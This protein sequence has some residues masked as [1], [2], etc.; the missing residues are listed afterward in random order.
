VIGVGALIVVDPFERFKH[1]GNDI[2]FLLLPADAYLLNPG[3]APAGNDIVGGN[4]VKNK[5][6]GV[7]AAPVA[8]TQFVGIA[9]LLYGS[10]NFVY[11]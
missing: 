7:N 2:R 6:G 11:R 10:A 5:T 8:K 4:A 9:L 3:G 1:H